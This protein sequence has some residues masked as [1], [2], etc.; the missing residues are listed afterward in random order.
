MQAR[1]QSPT[2]DYIIEVAIVN[3]NAQYR[4]YQSDITRTVSRAIAIANEA[5]RIYSE[6]NIRIVL[7]H[8]ITWTSG[9]QSHFSSS[10]DI[11]IQNFRTYSLQVQEPF[12]IHLFTTAHSSL[13]CLV[14][15]SWVMT[16]LK[17]QLVLLMSIRCV[18][19]H[20]WELFKTGIHPLVPLAVPLLMK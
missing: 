12:D 11:T 17:T 15:I 3:D 18:V 8:A 1:R 19:R 10:P 6:V 9:D 2:G 7:V 13:S 14:E 5:D 20:Q 4:H 16:S